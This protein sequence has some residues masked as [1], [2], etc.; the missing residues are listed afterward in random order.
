[1]HDHTRRRR[2]TAALLPVLLTALAA[3]QSG[4]EGGGADARAPKPSVTPVYEVRLDDQLSAA[5]KATT[6]AG[7]AAFSW[8]LTY[9]SDKGTAV[10]RTTGTQDYAKDTA[11]AERVLEVPRRF[12]ADA[13]AELGGRPGS[14]AAPETYVVAGN[15]VTYRTRQ[16]DWLRY[17]SSAPM[18]LVDLFDGVL[19]RAGE[20]APYGGTLAEVVRVSD[21]ERQPDKGA[22]GSRTYRLSVPPQTAEAALPP[23]FSSSLT[24]DKS[25]ARVPLTVVLDGEGRLT[26]ATADFGPV[27]DTLH[28]DG[29]LEGV[30]SLKAEYR[31]SRHGEATV[32]APP[33][34]AKRAQAAEKALTPLTKAKPGD[35]GSTDTGLGGSLELVRVTPCD[36]KAAELRVFGQVEV[37]ETIEGNPTGVA[38]KKAQEKCEAKYRAAPRAWVRGA[39][40][41]DTFY[42]YGAGSS[43][44]AYTGPDVDIEGTYACYVYTAGR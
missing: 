37:K 11:Q 7:S 3:C 9:G 18:E 32:P 1:M 23:Q 12:P 25:A 8:T 13:A 44:S 20:T 24:S 38:V 21:A 28:E 36:G 10:D 2:A 15:D 26:A 22:D 5:S 4:G 40:P 34:G 14:S 33:A 19:H 6:A 27:L 35:C 16:G 39:R 31:L 30:T 43:S 29:L 41:A 42:T 17:S